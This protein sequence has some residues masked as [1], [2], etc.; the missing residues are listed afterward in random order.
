M[1][2]AP[3]W[4]RYGDSVA[5]LAGLVLLWW[6]L[7]LW[8]GEEALTG[9]AET[10]ARARE[11]AGSRRFHAH[12]AES[13]AA[14]GYALL[15]A[16]LGGLALGT[17]LGVR[18]LA[19]QVAEPILVALYALPKITLYPVILLIFGLGLP[20]KVAFGAIHGVIPVTIFTLN[21]VRTIR[22]VYLKVARTLRLT[23]WQAFRTVWLPAALPEIVSGQRV[24][25]ALT[26]LGVLIGEMFAS[27]RGIGF[28][29]IN[30]IGLNDVPT[31]MA[32]AFL[33][34][35]FAATVSAILLKIDRAL[36]RRTARA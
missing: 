33:L 17:W 10:L 22:P 15:L 12:V 7:A 3:A 1:T 26:L 31:I 9:P 21:A 32:A 35:V 20:A 25:F 24:G 16:A 23:P 4:Q 28:V 34:A 19:G 2:G 11:L 6:L 18:P 36:H 8:A 14:L 13:L 30:A 27:Q 29:I 5:L